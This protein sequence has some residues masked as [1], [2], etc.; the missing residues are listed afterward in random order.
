MAPQ[1]GDALGL[2]TRG[3]GGTGHKGE[4]ERGWEPRCVEA[5]S[6]RPHEGNERERSLHKQVW[7]CAR[8]AL[9]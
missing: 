3:A 2:E 6:G 9:E 1:S 8:M 5:P 4:R 7:R